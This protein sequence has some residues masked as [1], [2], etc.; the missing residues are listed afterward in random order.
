MRT[1]K[2]EGVKILISIISYRHPWHSCFKAAAEEVSDPAFRKQWLAARAV[3]EKK[4]KIVVGQAQPS[5]RLDPQDTAEEDRQRRRKE[6][7]WLKH[8]S[9]FAIR[10]H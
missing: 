4:A 3:K 5:G 7:W 10:K 1:K 6:A 9:K 2:I 8:S